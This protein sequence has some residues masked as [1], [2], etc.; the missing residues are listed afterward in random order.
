M[1][2]MWKISPSI[3]TSFGHVCY[4]GL[5]RRKSRGFTLNYNAPEIIGT[6]KCSRML[7]VLDF[8]NLPIQ[9]KEG[10]VGTLTLKVI[11]PFVHRYIDTVEETWFSTDQSVY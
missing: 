9:V 2:R 4:N 5:T 7:L 8:L 6:L 11:S 1:T 10:F 3:R